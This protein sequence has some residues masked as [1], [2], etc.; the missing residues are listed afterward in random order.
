M[1][2]YLFNYCLQVNWHTVFWGIALQY[3]FALLILRTIWG[4]EMFKWLGDRV[5]E[6]L[7]YTLAGI[8][9]VFG[10]KYFEHFF[11]MKV[12]IWIKAH[13]INSPH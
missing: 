6:F 13:V 12:Y 3:L 7:E 8:I 1:K 4:Y 5:T 2:C 9:F 10:D 11:A